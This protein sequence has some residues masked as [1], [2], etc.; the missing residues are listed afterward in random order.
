M[1]AAAAARAARRYARLRRERRYVDD[2]VVAELLRGRRRFIRYTRW[3]MREAFRRADVAGASASQVAG[4]LAISE[5]HAQRLRS[6]LRR[7]AELR[8]AGDPREVYVTGRL[9]PRVDL[10]G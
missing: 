5:R 10:V 4:R 2:V 9:G 7:E 6:A 3:E 8:A 1:S